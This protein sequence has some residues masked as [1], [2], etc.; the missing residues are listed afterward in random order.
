MRGAIAVARGE[1]TARGLFSEAE[2]LEGRQLERSAD[3]LEDALRG[4]YILV[5]PYASCPADN[6]HRVP[7][8]FSSSLREVWLRETMGGVPY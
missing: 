3:E 2:D 5:R 4:V 1:D 7:S 6:A 8:D